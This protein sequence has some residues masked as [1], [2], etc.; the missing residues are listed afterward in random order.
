MDQYIFQRRTPV[1]EE[2]ST[3]PSAQPRDDISAN[4]VRDT[5][6]PADAET[7]ADTKKSNS[8]GDNEILIVD[9]ERGENVSDMMVLE[10]RTVELDE[11]QAGSDPDFIA[12]VYPKVYKILKHTTE[13]HVFLENPPSSLGTLLSMK[14]LDDAFT[15]GDQNLNDKPTEEEPEQ[16]CANLAKKNKKQDQTS[17]A[18][19][20]RIFTLEN[21]HLYSKID[22]YINENVKEAMFESGSYQ[23]QPEHTALYEA[24]KASMDR[25]NKEEFIEATAKYQKRRRDDQDP[26]PPPSKDSDQNKKKRHDDVHISDIEDTD[27]AHLPKIKTKPD[28]LK[29]VLE[30]ERPETPEPDWAVSLNDLPEPENSWANALANSYQDPKENKLLQKISDMGSF[31]KWYCKQIGKK[32][33]NKADLEG[34]TFKVD[35]ANP[36]GNR[37]VPDVSKPLP[38]GSPP[39]HVTIQPQYFFNKDLEYLVSGDKE[40]RNALSISKLKA[41]Y[42][43]DFGLEKL[44]PSLWM[45]SEREYDISAAYGISHWLFKHKEFYI[46]RHSSPSDLRA[47]RSHM[48]ILSVVNLKTFSRYGYIYLKEIVLHRAN[49]KEYKI[50]EADFKNLHSNDFKDLYL[51]HL[52]GNLKH[53]SG[54][55]KVHLFNVVNLYIRNIVIRN[56]VEGLQLGIESYQTKLNLTQPRWDASDFHFKEDYT[57]V[58]KPRAIIYRDK[59][60]QKKMMRESKVHKFSD[61]RLTRILEQLD[62]MVKDF[63]LFKFNLGMEHRIWSEDD[64]RRSKEFIEVIERRLNIKRIFRSLE[65][66]VSGRLRDVDYRLI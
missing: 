50:S 6:S 63:M 41:D 13:E 23:S 34:P 11:G 32:K 16:R 58:H 62:H 65:S 18:L 55:D 24:L 40:R 51:L 52:Q 53:L 9:E 61:G 33:L 44:V 64:K 25:E 35:L 54:A 37:V 31:I 46:T 43:P 57:I 59:N 42:Y 2:A 48:Q 19:S 21:H 22:K 45:E 8:E 20:S 39:C 10:E 28:W 36:V 14:N 66:F 12:I 7:R 1:T 60:N 27:V 56:R 49:Y 3:G 26:P 30:E 47:V 5:P 17:Q 38:L 4:V 29:P 15:Y